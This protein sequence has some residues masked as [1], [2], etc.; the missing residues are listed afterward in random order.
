MGPDYYLDLIGD[1][2]D[3]TKEPV[4]EKVKIPNNRTIYVVRD[5]LIGGGTKVRFL[6]FI[7]RNAVQRGVKEIVYGGCPATGYAQISLPILTNR[8]GIKTVLFMAKRNP[9]NYTEYQ[10][11]ALD[12]GAK[13]NWV[14][15]G[16][17]TVSTAR[18]KRYWA[19]DPK[20]RI[21]LPLGLE[22]ET[23]FGCI[24][25]V[26][27]SLRVRPTE[28]WS[29]G[30]SGTLNRGL[31]L[32][33]PKVPSN[34]VQVGHNMKPREIGRANH[35]KSEY[36]FEKPVKTHEAP[37]FPSAPTY[38]AKA[39]KFILDHANHRALFWNVGA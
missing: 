26:A 2:E 33:F 36:R 38:D 4:V 10:Q 15:N 13:I 39:W 18:A 24:I 29:V 21:V 34:V 16:M 23:A 28:I 25:K 22:H 6:D 7:V 11:R 20:K 37:P 32:A 30:S 19:R 27:R 12:L 35:F 17:L 8:Y 14:E 9:K 1:W 5:D 3:T 31:Q